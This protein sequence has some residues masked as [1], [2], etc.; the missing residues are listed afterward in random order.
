M[1]VSQVAAA[2][3]SLTVGR[4]PKPV[5]LG[6]QVPSTSVRVMYTPSSGVWNPAGYT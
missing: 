1:K 6:Y 3:S 2:P 5:A 4:R